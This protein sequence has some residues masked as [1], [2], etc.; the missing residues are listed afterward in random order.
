MQRDIREY[1]ELRERGWKAMTQ[2]DMRLACEIY[3][4]ALAAAQH[5]LAADP[6]VVDKAEVNLALARVQANKDEV[7]ERGL[8]EVL[9]RSGNSEVIRVAAQCLAK[10][11][12]HRSEHEKA[13]RYAQLA[14][15]KAEELGE[16]LQVLSCRT[17]LGLLYGNQSYYDESLEQY[18]AVLEL[19]EEGPL[20][21]PAQ[22]A[23][24]WTLTTDHVGYVLA[25]KGLLPEAK[26]KLEGAHAKARELRITELLAEIGTDLCFVNLRL[27]NLSEARS[28]GEEALAI[29]E[30]HGYDFFR[31]NCYYLLGEVASQGGNDEVADDYFRR[32]AEFFPQFAFLGDFLR[33]YDISSMINLKEFA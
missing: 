5:C 28:Y 33:E 8:R 27:G 9:I 10:I 22:Q 7:A 21:D 32:L 17:T 3:E 20:G 14:L 2:G 11:H 29:A 26:E 23:Y 18:A 16:P 24:Y 30:E 19:L 12:S 4:S 1:E 6:D 13:H 15:E 25:M 31:R